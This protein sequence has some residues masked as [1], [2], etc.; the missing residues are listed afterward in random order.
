MFYKI[1]TSITDYS[2]HQNSLDLI[3][4]DSYMYDN[5]L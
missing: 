5:L 3:F 1:I 4:P 2:I